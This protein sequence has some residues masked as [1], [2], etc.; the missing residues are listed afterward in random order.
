MTH[1]ALDSETHTLTHTFTRTLSHTHAHT[2]TH[3]LSHTLLTLLPGIHNAEVSLGEKSLIQS[4]SPPITHTHTHTLSDSTEEI[5][6]S[7]SHIAVLG[8]AVSSSLIEILPETVE[9]MMDLSPWCLPSPQ[10]GKSL[11][12]DLALDP[13]RP[14]S[15]ISFIRVSVPGG[16][17]YWFTNLCCYVCAPAALKDIIGALTV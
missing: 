6:E 7:H 12:R 4:N 8:L 16:A 17:E 2:L 10:L 3:T 11:Q 14:G 5:V 9:G 15:P 1:S 13:Y